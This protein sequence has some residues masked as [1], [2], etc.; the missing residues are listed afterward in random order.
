[1]AS[2][3]LQF[4][5]CFSFRWSFWH[6]LSLQLT[7]AACLALSGWRFMERRFKAVV[8]TYRLLVAAGSG[9]AA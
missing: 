6:W 5:F 7:S 2:S 3:L 9:P 8:F 1:L 4:I